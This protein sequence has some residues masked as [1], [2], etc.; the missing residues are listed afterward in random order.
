M[1]NK[2]KK[3]IVDAAEGYRHGQ[4]E[5]EEH[6][7]T[8]EYSNKKDLLKMLNE[9]FVRRYFQKYKITDRVQRANT[10]AELKNWSGYNKHDDF[11]TIACTECVDYW[12]VQF[13]A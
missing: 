9:K 4:T 10:R 11:Q 12:I 3:A 5:N 2:K 13:N 1:M 8:F 7:G 6:I